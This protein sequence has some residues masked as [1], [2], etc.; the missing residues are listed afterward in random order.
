MDKSILSKDTLYRLG[1]LDPNLFLNE[2]EEEHSYSVNTSKEEIDKRSD[3]E[4]SMRKDENGK[5]EC[6]CEKRI[7]SKPFV[8]KV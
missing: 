3:C 4:K 6:D 1:V 5:V 2:S 7:L 8:A